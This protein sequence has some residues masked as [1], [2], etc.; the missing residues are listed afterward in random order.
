MTSAWFVTGTDTE[1]GKTHAS[2][3]LL[4]ALQRH[5]WRVVGM[6]PV[7]AGLDAAGQPPEDVRRLQAASNVHAPLSQLCPFALAQP[8]SPHIAAAAEGRRV[9]WPPI[10]AAFTALAAQADAV[11]VEGVGGFYAPLDTPIGGSAWT[12]ADLAAALALP[13]ILVVGLRLGCLNHALLTAQAI[14]ARGLTAA[15]WIGNAIDP[16]MRAREQNLATLRALLPM[17]CL[18]VLPHG[19]P[20]EAAAAALDLTPLLPTRA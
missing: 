7:A 6:K 2:A 10:A 3:A 17:P 19:T 11:V 18:G 9:Q 5:G 1:I 4:H 12:V 13:V 8:V 16:Q 14:A 20:P 15:G